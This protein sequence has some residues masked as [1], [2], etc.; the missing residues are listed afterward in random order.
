M[1]IEERLN[2]IGELV[3]GLSE[4]SSGN[5]TILNSNCQMLG[6]RLEDLEKKVQELE[7]KTASDLSQEVV[8]EIEASHEQD[9]LWLA[10]SKSGRLYSFTEKPQISSNG[11]HWSGRNIL[12]W[13]MRQY[14]S[15]TYEN[16]PQ[17][18]V[19]ESAISKTETS[20]KGYVPTVDDFFYNPEKENSEK[21][22]NQEFDKER[23]SELLASIE[24][25]TTKN[26]NA[27]TKAILL[28]CAELRQLLG[29]E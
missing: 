3:K 29:N 17:K 21:R 4:Q 1:N 9:C 28:S 24:T 10:R 15:L 22:N 27:A 7:T 16:S 13:G 18:L 20:E 6:N 19:L 14:K 25:S 26:S 23:A 2:H 8:E 12:Y 5:M 11:E